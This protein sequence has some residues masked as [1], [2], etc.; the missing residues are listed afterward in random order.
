MGQVRIP[1][2]PTPAPRSPPGPRPFSPT[3]MIAE[4]DNRWGQRACSPR[5]LVGIL[6]DIPRERGPRPRRRPGSEQH[7]QRSGNHTTARSNRGAPPE[8]WLGCR[9]PVRQPGPRPFSPTTMIAERDTAGTNPRS[10]VAA[11]AQTLFAINTLAETKSRRGA[12][13]AQSH[14]AGW[15]SANASTPTRT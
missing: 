12:T 7:Q 1:Q 8:R 11:G 9:S 14:I 5:A 6:P 3:T 15:F 13:R 4:R 10:P 2:A